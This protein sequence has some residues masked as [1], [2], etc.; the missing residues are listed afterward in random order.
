MGRLRFW[1]LGFEGEVFLKVGVGGRG[2][3]DNELIDRH[4]SVA[5]TFRHSVH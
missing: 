5:S 3:V 2:G 1:E 4:F